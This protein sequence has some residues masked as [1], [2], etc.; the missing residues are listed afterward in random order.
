VSSIPEV[1]GDA[2]LLVQPYATNEIRD[3][4]RA[5]HQ[6][7]DLRIALENRGRARAQKFGMQNYE[8]HLRWFEAEAR[9]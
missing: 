8:E 6:D 9:Y 3:A 1:A 2:A 4:I 5:L 7:K